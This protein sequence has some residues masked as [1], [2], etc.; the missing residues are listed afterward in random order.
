MAEMRRIVAYDIF[1]GP[2]R[3]SAFRT[4]TTDHNTNS[5][6]NGEVRES[7]RPYYTDLNQMI[8]FVW[9]LLTFLCHSS[10]ASRHH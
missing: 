10:V 4:N 5:I 6:I 1:R 8:V 3:T 7:R 9:T 2:G